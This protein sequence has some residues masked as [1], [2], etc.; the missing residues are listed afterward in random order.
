MRDSQGDNAYFITL[1]KKMTECQF[2]KLV[3]VL[4]QAGERLS[5]LV[6]D[7][8]KPEKIEVKI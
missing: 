5:K 4:K 6:R 1:G 8:K 2:N 3:K 7:S